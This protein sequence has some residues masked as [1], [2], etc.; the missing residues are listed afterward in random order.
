MHAEHLT[1]D[2]VSA[3]IE[4]GSRLLLAGDALLLAQLPAGDWIAGTFSETPRLANRTGQLL[5]TEL[6]ADVV[7]IA[8]RRYTPDDIGGV[9]NDA[10]ANGISFIIIPAESD[11]HYQFALKAPEF[12]NF[13]VRPLIGWISGGPEDGSAD[14]SARVFDGRHDAASSQL[15]TVMHVSLPA[16]K[17]AD[18][19][20]VNIFLPGDGDDIRFPA[21]G[22]STRDAYIN[23]IRCNF[24]D[25]LREQR[26]DT[27]LPLVA[28]YHGVALNTSIREPD[29]RPEVAFY[30]PV[31][32]G[33]TYRHARPVTDYADRFAAQLPVGLEHQIV[34]SCNCVLNERYAMR[35]GMQQAGLNGPTSLGEIAYLLLNQTM[36]YVRIIK[37]PAGS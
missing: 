36:V 32:S 19:G 17:V 28:D 13:A 5:C 12:E 14:S 29:E 2:E 24:R 1:L 16:G 22:F 30:A 23:G 37:L 8:I 3:K 26:L 25:Y 21:D 11:V 20:I 31:F 15:A 27:R 4:Q 34:F 35:G 33:L 6:P 9:Y 18:I 7:N 10:P